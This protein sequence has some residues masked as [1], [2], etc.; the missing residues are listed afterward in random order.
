MRLR[1]ACGQYRTNRM[2]TLVEA[3][4]QEQNVRSKESTLSLKS[5]GVQSRHAVRF[6][7]FFGVK[8]KKSANLGGN[9][10]VS[11]FPQG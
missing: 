4:W 2:L 10:T 1:R 9:R 11:S 8:S 5:V 7:G 3:N 6:C